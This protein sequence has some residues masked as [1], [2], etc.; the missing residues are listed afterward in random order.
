MARQ[1]L[2]RKYP[3]AGGSLG[4]G[5]LEQRPTAA[6]AISKCIS[7]WSEVEFQYALL[8]ASLL[9]ANSIPAV[10]VFHALRSA[11]AQRNVINAAA[12]AAVPQHAD[13]VAAVLKSGETL[14]N[15]RADLAHG[16]FGITSAS[17]EGVLWIEAK[18]RVHHTVE[19][20]AIN[21]KDQSARNID[22]LQSVFDQVFIYEVRDLERLAEAIDAHHLTV[23]Q[24]IN[25]VDCQEP[26]ERDRL[27]RQLCSDPRILQTR[28]VRAPV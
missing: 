1:K 22:L 4:P 26:M 24:L 11:R 17:P 2:R 7:H 14:E 19:V 15:E 27:Y 21:F 5:F 12:E 9:K 16:L 20:N 28:L 23:R 25:L 18:H 10:A 6:A 8:L 3:N 13:L